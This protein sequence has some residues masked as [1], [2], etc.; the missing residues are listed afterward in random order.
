MT[1]SP[2][3]PVIPMSPSP[4]DPVIPLTPS[5]PI[6]IAPPYDYYYPRWTWT[7]DGT[8]TSDSI[9]LSDNATDTK[10]DFS[11]LD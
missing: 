9:K 6:W 5:A 7:E 8:S 1:P 10:W 2:Y 4:Y 3:D 11:D